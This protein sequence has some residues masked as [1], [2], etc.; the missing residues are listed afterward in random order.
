MTKELKEVLQK[1]GVL[2]VALAHLRSERPG[3]KYQSLEEYYRSLGGPLPDELALVVRISKDGQMRFLREGE[4]DVVFKD[5]EGNKTG[6]ITVWE[7][8]EDEFWYFRAFR[9]ALFDLEID[10]PP[11][12]YEIGITYAYAVFEGY[13]SDILRG[14]IREHPRLMG[15]QRQVTYEQ[16]LDSSSKEALVE[17]MIDRE[18]RDL[19][20][21][22][23]GDVLRKMREKLGF[24]SL[25]DIHD[26]PLAGL[27]LL[28]N[29]LLHN[30]G[31]VDSKLAELEP[32]RKH[33]DKILLA[34]EDVD[35]AVNV[36]RTAGHAIDQAFEAG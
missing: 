31:R 26:K 27:S 25:T 29:C 6:V 21:L 4:H 19:T 28:R 18:V 9:P 33:S 8:P 22:P 16:V 10:L 24:R 3:N 32:T 20:Y 13:L 30:G 17:T 12:I 34:M 14:R 5:E 7:L 15:G 36:L 11:F 23:I 35:H 2:S 1:Y